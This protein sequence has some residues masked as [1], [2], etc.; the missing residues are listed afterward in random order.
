VAEYPG[1]LKLRAWLG[2]RATTAATLLTALGLL[3]LL[4]PA[5]LVLGYK[6]LLAWVYERPEGP[7]ADNGA[8]DVGK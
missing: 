3:V 2:G 8:V 4:V 5:V 6:L 7:V 1:Y